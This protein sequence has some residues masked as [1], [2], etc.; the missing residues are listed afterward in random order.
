MPVHADEEPHEG[1]AA[2]KNNI[3]IFVFE[4]FRSAN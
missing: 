1:M 4:F 2:A 3:R